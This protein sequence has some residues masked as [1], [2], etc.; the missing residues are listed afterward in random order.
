MLR[1]IERLRAAYPRQA[2]PPE[3]VAM[4]V[5]SLV[6][7][8]PEDVALAVS[9]LVSRSEWLPSIAEIRRQVVEASLALPRAAAAWELIQTVEGRRDAPEVVR[10]ALALVGG[11]YALRSTTNPSVLAGQFRKAYDELR[12]DEI[13]ARAENVSGSIA[14]LQEGETR[15]AHSFGPPRRELNP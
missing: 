4:Y 6:D 13:R 15:A 12:E 2:F 1:T 7:L 9:A 11:P 14:G 8:P 5:V 10:R 3:S